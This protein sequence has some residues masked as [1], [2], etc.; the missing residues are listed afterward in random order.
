MYSPDPELVQLIK[1]RF[2]PTDWWTNNSGDWF[3]PKGHG[4][5]YAFMHYDRATTKYTFENK[6]YT[7]QE[8][9]RVL[10]LYAF[11]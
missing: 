9:I 6:Q 1:K 4:T 7:E 5:K 3:C 2:G 8:V 11:A 10:K